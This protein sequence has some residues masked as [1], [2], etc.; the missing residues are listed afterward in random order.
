MMEWTIE[1]YNYVLPDEK[2]ARFPVE[3]RDTSKLLIYRQGKIEETLFRELKEYIPENTF[4]VF[5]NTKVIPARLFFEKKNGVL[6]EI[7]LLNPV[8]PS[9]IVSQ[10]METTGSCV[11]VCM[12]GNKKR[13]KEK[14][15]ANYTI[16]TEHESIDLELGAELIDSEQ[17]LV[18]FTWNDDRMSF[19][20]IVKF[21]GQI[22]LP[23]YLKRQTE[24]RDYETYQTVYSQ[25]EGA[26]AAP[27][28]GLHFTD[29]VFEE[30]ASKEVKHDFVTL[31]V[32]AGTF[33]PIKVKNV[34]EHPMHC[35]QIV[36]ERSFIKNLLDNANFVIPVGTTSMRSL[37][38]LYWF[39]V[40]LLQGEERFFI[41]KLFP[42]ESIEQEISLENSL[43][44]ILRWM[45]HN[46]F[47]TI[48][49]ETEI[50][51][52]PSYRFRVCKGI[53]TNFHQPDSTLMLLV[54]AL[55]GDD[56]KKIYDFALEND[57]RFLSYGDSSLLIP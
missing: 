36:F 34:L 28:A 1:K 30:L 25:K 31:H 52:F 37:E 43:K 3:P 47:D 24:H 19:A 56:C 20:S 51:I 29:R 12:I 48:I 2:I 17:N 45:E 41:E 11:W 9:S 10:A 15:F 42:Y 8:L 21:F 4:L 39:G 22:P 49:G 46:Q 26:V 35:E 38:S 57:F 16:S 44:A 6:I 55:V 13:F 53:I 32:G 54:G 5:N 18:K 27:T 33:Q 50:F 14:V 7:F 40:K 23:P